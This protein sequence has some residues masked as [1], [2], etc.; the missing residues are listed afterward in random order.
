MV[1][2]NQLFTLS[3]EKLKRRYE[4][5]IIGP[6][7]ALIN[8]PVDS[9]NSILDFENSIKSRL[10]KYSNL[11]LI[12][13]IDPDI[14]KIVQKYWNKEILDPRVHLDEMRS[15]KSDS[16]IDLMK[17]ACSISSDA[18]VKAMAI[19]SPGIGEW[20]IQ[21]LIESFHNVQEYE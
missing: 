14:D 12:I 6:E 11:Y 7:G 15:I 4:G 8:W 21:A 1:H 13:G 9:S 17:T 18:H 19:S 2:G 3:Q 10:N 20:E 16:E 5:R